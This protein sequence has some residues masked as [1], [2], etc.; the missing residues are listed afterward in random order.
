MRGGSLITTGVLGCSQP[1]LWGM[2]R[3]RTETPSA[4]VPQSGGAASPVQ[5]M[6]GGVELLQQ[7]LGSTPTNPFP[8]EAQ[9][10]NSEATAAAKLRKGPP[11]ILPRADRPSPPACPP[12]AAYPILF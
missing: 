8:A 7:P 5:G 3:T 12:P 11:T 9:R 1:T 10:P 6:L 4:K 2:E